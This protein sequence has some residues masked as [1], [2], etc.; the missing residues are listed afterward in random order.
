MLPC[1]DTNEAI[2]NVTGA[3]LT[4]SIFLGTSNA[5]TVQP[6]LD[7]ERTVFYRL[8]FCFGQWRTVQ[9]AAHNLQQPSD[10]VRLT[11]IWGLSTLL[12]QALSDI[13]KAVAC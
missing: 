6:V 11:M 13:E 2:Q 5:S 8:A 9:L 7:T 3:L 12:A 10:F 1:R 4:A